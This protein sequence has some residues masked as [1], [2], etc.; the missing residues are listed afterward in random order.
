[1][2]LGETHFA[3]SYPHAFKI[4]V[5]AKRSKTGL[6]DIK[7]FVFSAFLLFSGIIYAQT[8]LRPGFIITNHQDTLFGDIDYR[9]D[10]LMGALCKFKADDLVVTDYYPGD[11]EAYGFVVGKFYVTKLVNE[12]IVFL[13]YLISG[14]ADIFY[15]RDETGDHYYIEKAG[16]PLSEIPYKE[17]IRYIKSTP[18]EYRSK[19]HIGLISLYMQD[20]PDFQAEIAT[21]KK[22][23][24]RNLIKLAEKY[25]NVVCKDESCIIYEKKMPL[26]S[27]S[28]EPFWGPVKYIVANN[29]FNEFGLFA[30]VNSPRTN[31]KIYVKTGL[32]FQRIQ[33]DSSHLDMYR[34]P[35]QLQ[36]IYQGK[37]LQPRIG[38]GTNLFFADIDDRI[39]ILTHTFN[40]HAGLNYHIFDRWYVFGMFNADFSPSV[41]WVIDEEVSFEI[42]S[43]GMSL[44]LFINL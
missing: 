23:E 22:P 25:H 5:S 37:K 32:S 8:D 17:E 30:Y 7:S 40:L 27:L 42:F 18:Y 4:S 28:L 16:M 24:H 13:E 31:E 9:G 44:G 29:A 1:M 41:D 21:I 6:M 34:I 39:D 15:L 38:L 2:E 12:K 14:Q 33:G 11:I 3:Y 10:E 36:Y 19:T 43:Y 35:L 20:A 26:I